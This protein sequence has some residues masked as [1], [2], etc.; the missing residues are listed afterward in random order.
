MLVITQQQRYGY[1]WWTTLV[2]HSDH[3]GSLFAH[4]VHLQFECALA[5]NSKHLKLFFPKIFLGPVEFA[6]QSCK[7][8]KIYIYPPFPPPLT[9]D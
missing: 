6:L 3:L 4:F 2:L 8:L 1:V 7:C 9:N 5:F